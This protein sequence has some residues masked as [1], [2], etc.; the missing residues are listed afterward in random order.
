VTYNAI[1]VLNNDATF[2]GRVIA[3]ITQ[4]CQVFMEGYAT[5]PDEFNF[6][7]DIFRSAPHPLATTVLWVAQY[8][9]IAEAAGDPPTQS[10]VTDAQ[11]QDAVVAGYHFLA[12]IAYNQDGTPWGG[13]YNADLTGSPPVMPPGAPP[14]PEAPTVTD[15]SPTSGNAGTTVTVTGTLLTDTT[16]IVIRT[17]LTGL[18]VVS[19]TQ[20]TGAIANYNP[21]QRGYYDVL[22][23]V[24]GQVI[25]A[26]GGQFQLT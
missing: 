6:A 2:Q 7:C 1:A 24:G 17:S 10:L 5:Q 21:S 4:E 18:T 20:V 11:I 23:T 15:F 8:P 16:G 13:Q 19:D 26:P 9:G 12:S 14:P 3:C 25:T 22:V